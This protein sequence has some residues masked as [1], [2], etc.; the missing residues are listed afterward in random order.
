MHTIHTV[1]VQDSDM[2]V[3]LFQP[4]GPGPH[5]GIILAQHIPVGHTGVE[6]DVFT[7]KTAARYAENGYAVA[8]PFI[9]HWWPKEAGIEIK[10]EE[11]RDDWTALDLRATFDLLADQDNV[12]SARIAIIG[13]CW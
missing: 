10:R 2:E 8:V 6:N 7:L 1:T 3:F 12:D 11:F 13:H 9:F 5:P 4:E